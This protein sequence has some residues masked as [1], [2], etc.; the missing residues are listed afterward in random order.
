MVGYLAVQSSQSKL[1]LIA[2]VRPKSLGRESSICLG[3]SFLLSLEEIWSN[4][5]IFFVWSYQHFSFKAKIESDAFTQSGFNID[6]W[7]FT[8]KIDVEIAAS[9]SFDSENLN[10]AF[11]ISGFEEF[12]L[13]SCNLDGIVL[14]DFRAYH[15]IGEGAIFSPSPK[16][17]RSSFLL[18]LQV[19]PE[20]F[21]AFVYPIRYVLN[22]MRR[23]ICLISIL[24]QF[25]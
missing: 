17:R 2:V 22:S 24:L 18:P 7:C 5:I 3:N 23:Q 12:I 9:I 20:Q 21:V 6:F 11:Y 10:L 8:D 19:T 4:D 16:L 1:C 14:N 25:L 15:I 13:V